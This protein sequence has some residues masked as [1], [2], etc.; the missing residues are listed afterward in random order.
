MLM[1]KPSGLHC[2]ASSSLDAALRSDL[3]DVEDVGSTVERGLKR[4]ASFSAGRDATSGATAT[5][6]IRIRPGNVGP[7]H[8]ATRVEE[9]RKTNDGSMVEIVLS[10]TS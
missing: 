6:W 3:P 5:G 8:I 10:E 9:K 2:K 4:G 7:P 1:L